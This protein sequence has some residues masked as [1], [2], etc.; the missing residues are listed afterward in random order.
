MAFLRARR[1]FHRIAWAGIG[2]QTIPLALL[3][4]GRTLEWAVIS[5]LGGQL[6]SIIV[7]A[8]AISQALRG[9]R[10][11]LFFGIGFG[12]FLVGILIF[13]SALFGLLPFNP[14]TQNAAEIGSAVEALLLSLALAHKMQQLSEEK[15]QQQH[16]LFAAQTEKVTAQQESI[17]NK[18]IALETIQEYSKKLEAEVSARTS[19]LVETQQKLVASEKMAALGVFTAGMAHEINNPAN[20]VSVG[21]QNTAAQIGQLRSFVHGLLADDPDPEIVDGFEQHFSRLEKSNATVT[22]GVSRIEKVIRQLRSDHPEGDIGMQPADVVATLKSA[23]QVFSPTLKIPVHLTSNLEYRPTLACAVAEMQQVFIALL[24]NAAHA[25]EDAKSDRGG[26]YEGRI[27]LTSALNNDYLVITIS[28]N[29]LGIPSENIEKIFDPFFTTKV[30]GRGAGLGLSMARDVVKRHRGNLEVRSTL[31]EGA[32][33][34]LR[35]PLD[36]TGSTARL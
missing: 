31:G 26:G 35:L 12:A 29:G 21:A 17:K 34:M 16:A 11:A 8:T 20:F 22:E 15:D 25:I 7:I 27:N 2:L 4:S 18:Q 3:W 19:E 10:A 5:T 23:W 32:T 9:S 36:Q 6:T 14:L 24:S 13:T 1:G 28:D 30:V 33:F